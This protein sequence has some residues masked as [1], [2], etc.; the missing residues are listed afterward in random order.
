MT[1]ARL[2]RIPVKDPDLVTG[3]FLFRVFLNHDFSVGRYTVHYTWAY[4]SNTYIDI[5]TFEIVAG[6]DPDGA[7]NSM[8]FYHRPHADFV[9]Y[10]L[11]SGKI[12]KRRN[13]KVV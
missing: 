12:Q 5:D 9:V 3:Q 11:T 6:G 7:I 13:P 10:Q 8:Y 2:T 4:S 1:P